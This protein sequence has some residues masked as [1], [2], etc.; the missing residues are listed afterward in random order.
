MF[1]RVLEKCT[2]KGKSRNLMSSNDILIMG[3]NPKKGDK[4]R[5]RNVQFIDGDKYMSCIKVRHLLPLSNIDL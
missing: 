4:V 3:G 5:K 1:F 2:V